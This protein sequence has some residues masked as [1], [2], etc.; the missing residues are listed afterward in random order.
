MSRGLGAVQRLIVDTI[1][2]R[3]GAALRVRREWQNCLVIQTALVR[4]K[5]AA[6]TGYH[7]PVVAI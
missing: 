3:R 2:A 6:A 1:T 7:M 5:P 4:A